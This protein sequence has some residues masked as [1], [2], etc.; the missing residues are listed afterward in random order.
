[1]TA[2]ESSPRSSEPPADL[3]TVALALGAAGGHP[4]YSP[5]GPGRSAHANKRATLGLALVALLVGA[6][7]Q[8][9]MATPDTRDGPSEDSRAGVVFSSAQAGNCLSWPA[10][11]PDKPSFV[12]CR[13]D[14]LFE[15][16]KS[17]GMGN[18]GE[19]CQAAVRQYLGARYDP[20]SRFTIS[21]LWAGDNGGAP[22]ADRNLLCGLQLLGPGAKPIPFKGRVAELDQSKIW[23][24]G[25]CLG[26]D[27]ATNRSTDIP[28]DCAT[29]H[30]VEV[31]G[32]VSLAERFPGGPPATADQDAFVKDECT[33]MADGYLAPLPL[34]ATGLSLKYDALSEDSWLAGSRQ[35]ACRLESPGG[36]G[37]Q[38]LVGSV[39]GQAAEAAPPPPPPAAPPPEAP[40]PAAPPPE[41]APPPEP[42]APEPALPTQAPAAPVV[43]A[44]T[45]SPTPS[46]TPT[47]TTA[48][49][50]PPEPTPTPSESSSPPPGIIELP[51]LPP[52]TL[53]GYVPPEPTP[54]APAGP[55]PGPPPG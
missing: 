55:L 19:P 34:Q 27:P 24:A 25:T 8:L 46:P 4:L 15:V 37:L 35:I 18:F 53:P 1:V 26:I 30:A 7:I 42:R 17:V 43:T 21:V 29:A 36:Q 32:A 51:G 22:P 33:R 28:V 3:Q 9:L 44:A 23:P 16:A 12:Q 45:P 54:Q 10:D 52:I 50:P 13:D 41:V 38:T 11:A 2:V 47:T 39:K 48:P 6:V 49:S 14:H 5:C 31:A 40:P 20:S